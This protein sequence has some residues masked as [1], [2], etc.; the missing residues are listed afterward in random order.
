MTVLKI[1][2]MAFCEWETD[3]GVITSEDFAPEGLTLV[4]GS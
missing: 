2:P 3:K 1:L 4:S